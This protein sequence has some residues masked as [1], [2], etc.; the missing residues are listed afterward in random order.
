MNIG[1]TKV[2]VSGKN[3]GDVERL[4]KWPCTVCGKGVGS[5]SIRC[6][7]CSGWV[8]KRCSGVKG[9][10]VRAEDTFVCKMCERAGDE[11][12]RNV[13]DSLDLGNGVHL[14]N[15]RKFCYLGDML[16][17]GGGVNSASVARARCAW[18]KV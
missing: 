11:E 4:G 7:G 12:D 14:E 2:M 1:K 6:T 15:V 13:D 16:N 8:H 10:L 5:N 18:R 9:S 17:G 3:C